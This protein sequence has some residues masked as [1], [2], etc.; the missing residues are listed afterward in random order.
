MFLILD[1]LYIVKNYFFPLV[2]Q[3]HE[4]HRILYS[5]MTNKVIVVNFFNDTIT[6]SRIVYAD[7]DKGI[8]YNI[9]D[10][11]DIQKINNRDK[12]ELFKHEPKN[13]KPFKVSKKALK[14]LLGK[15]FKN[16][17]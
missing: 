1:L 3:E 5:P 11:S 7:F 12:K 16:Y 4:Y 14:F 9:K 10:I 2:Y 17:L 15:K 8:C 13:T 6:G